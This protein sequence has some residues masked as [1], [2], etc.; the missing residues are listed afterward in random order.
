MIHNNLE[1]SL[2]KEIVKGQYSADINAK[3]KVMEKQL[4][5]VV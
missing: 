1:S 2:G 3:K 5:I 4:F